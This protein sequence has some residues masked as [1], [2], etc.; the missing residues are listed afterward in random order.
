MKTLVLST[1]GVC[2]KNATRIRTYSHLLK[3]Q[4]K[5]KWLF[6]EEFDGCD[7]CFVRDDYLTK[8]TAL[9]SQGTVLVVLNAK[10]Y[11]YD[12][13]RYKYS[14]A[15]PLTGEKIKNVLNQISKEETFKK[16][17]SAEEPEPTAKKSLFGGFKS[18]LNKI[19]KNFYTGD[20]RNKVSDIQQRKVDR[21]SKLTQA[22]SGIGKTRH[23]IIFMGSPGCGKTTLIQTASKGTALGSDVKSTDSVSINKAKTTVGID[24]ALVKVNEKM[25]LNLIGTP[26]QVK[27]NYLWDIV[28][29]SADAFVIV[30]DMSRPE[31]ME[32]LDFYDQFI[33][34]E[35]GVSAKIYCAL[36]HVDESLINVSK[37]AHSIQ[38]QKRYVKKIF[39]L[40]S[41]EEKDVKNMLD[42]LVLSIY[43][44][45]K[46]KLSAQ[47]QQ[48]NVSNN[49]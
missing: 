15:P 39:M 24:F 1:A 12:S 43:K 45:N 18:V 4:L 9:E 32:F 7:I 16:R 11:G 25:E 22:I 17:T 8:V 19:K 41:R 23:K 26:G 5:D 31:P 2:Y 21:V 34:S 40:D 47:G 6:A 38:Q 27:Y 3:H 10:G 37:F 29:K 14:I 20:E 42:Y 35:I 13:Q 48:N 49:F 30:L 46:E 44:A 36:T 28:G 33:K